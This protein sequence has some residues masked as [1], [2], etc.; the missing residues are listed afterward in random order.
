MV[1]QPRERRLFGPLSARCI[2]SRI[3]RDKSVRSQTYAREIGMT[4]SLLTHS[5]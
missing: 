5:E 2:A 4:R 3:V 1:L